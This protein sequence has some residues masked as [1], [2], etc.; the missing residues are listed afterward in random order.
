MDSPLKSMSQ[1]ESEWESRW[2]KEIPCICSDFAQQEDVGCD[3]HGEASLLIR[4]FI[5]KEIE[6]RDIHTGELVHKDRKVAVNFIIKKYMN[7]F[8]GNPN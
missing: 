3:A 1:K 5:K 8:Y 2:E 6:K 4:R 7:D